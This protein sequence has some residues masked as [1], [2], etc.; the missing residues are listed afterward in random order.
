MACIR[1]RSSIEMPVPL[2]LSTAACNIKFN[3]AGVRRWRFFA[4]L[5]AASC[6][7]N[8]LLRP[9]HGSVNERI[10]L[11][12]LRLEHKRRHGAGCTA[13]EAT[14]AAGHVVAGSACFRSSVLSLDKCDYRRVVVVC[15]TVSGKRSVVRKRLRR[16]KSV[17]PLAPLPP[18]VLLSEIVHLEG[19]RPCRAGVQPNPLSYKDEQ[20]GR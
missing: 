3:S 12:F 7:Q 11:Q 15:A 14:G 9:G 5:F 8:V 4:R 19:R 13:D 10:S 6:S 2:H 1:M 18:S 20:T 17:P 16:L